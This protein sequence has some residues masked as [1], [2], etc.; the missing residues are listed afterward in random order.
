MPK[1]TQSWPSERFCRKKF[2]PR[3]RLSKNLFPT[4]RS[5]TALKF[6]FAVKL[7]AFRHPKSS[8][9]T[10]TTTW[11]P[12]TSSETRPSSTTR[13]KLSSDLEGRQRILRAVTPARQLTL[14]ELQLQPGETLFKHL[15][16]RFSTWGARTPRGTWEA[17]RGYAK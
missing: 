15:N 11:R 5:S 14:P 1:A 17:H 16:Q 2:L 13:G 4:F 3:F 7:S 10:T 8:G 12:T 9:F 6:C